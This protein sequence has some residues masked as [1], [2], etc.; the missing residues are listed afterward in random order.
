MSNSRCWMG[1]LAALAA[2]SA[3]S[4]LWAAEAKL[5]FTPDNLAIDP[6]PVC[7]PRSRSIQGLP[8][9]AAPLKGQPKLVSANPRFFEIRLGPDQATHALILDESKGTG[10]GYD[11]LYLDAE[12]TG[13]LADAKPVTGQCRTEGNQASCL[14]KDCQALVN[15]GGQRLPWR[16]DA[17]ACTDTSLGWIKPQ[18]VLTVCPFGYYGGTIQI[19]GQTVRAAVVD[20]ACTGRYDEPLDLGRLALGSDGGLDLPGSQVLLDLNGDGRFDVSGPEAFPCTRYV[21]LNGTYYS[22]AV[23]PN[24]QS[25]TLAKS[26]VPQG[27]IERERGGRFTLGLVSSECGMVTVSCQGEPA[28]LPAGRYRLL[29]CSLALSRADGATWQATGKGSEKGSEIVVAADA[30]TRLKLGPPLVL[31]ATVD[32]ASQ[33]RP[34]AVRPGTELSLG[35]DVYGQAGER[36]PSGVLRQGR[37]PEPPTVRVLAANGKVIE[38][39]SFRFG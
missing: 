18:T 10:T 2:L 24:G 27:T 37:S 33:G 31:S 32:A 13:N 28:K 35:I 25:L 14:F 34:D 3:A 23:A 11:R 17:F 15:Y 6:G 38:K 16:F 39:G 4:D 7:I 1:A 8:A 20:A 12:A 9:P 26:K 19:D 29:W 22:M 36:Y 21:Q 5:Q 30:P